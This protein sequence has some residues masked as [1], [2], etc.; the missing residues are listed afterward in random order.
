MNTVA[1]HEPII[2][3][4]APVVAGIG[5][6]KYRRFVTFSLIGA[7]CWVPSMLLIGYCIPTVVDPLLRNVFGPEF[8]TAN[9]IEKAI[10]LIVLISIS[11]GLFAGAKKWLAKRKAK[12]VSVEPEVN[13]PV[14]TAIG[15]E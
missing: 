5:N 10:I 3:T 4:F 11:P 13:T 1:S 2:R 7:I 15:P 9:H 8:K 14:Y 12:S 6:M